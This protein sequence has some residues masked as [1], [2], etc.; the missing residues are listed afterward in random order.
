MRQR[1]I[2][3]TV[4]KYWL[5]HFIHKGLCSLCGNTGNINTLG[6][7]I[8]SKGVHSGKINYCIC[9]NGQSARIASMG[10]D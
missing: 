3:V 5:K 6:R 10:E 9:P 2:N 1:E 4:T 8:S 7:A